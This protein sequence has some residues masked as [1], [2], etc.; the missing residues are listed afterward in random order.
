MHPA[1]N[2]KC[3]SSYNIIDKT[4]VLVHGAWHGSWCWIKIAENMT[5]KGYNVLTPDLPGH[6]ERGKSSFCDVS[7]SDYVTHMSHLINQ[8][9]GQVVLVGHSM[10]GV[11]I[12]QVAENMPHK[13]YKLVY[14]SGFVPNDRG[15]L[16]DEEQNAL[17]PTV[18]PETKIEK[19]K[20]AIHLN[21]QAASRLF[22]NSS[23]Q[24]DIRFALKCLQPQPLLPFV[25]K[26]TLSSSKFGSVSKLYIE[27]LR[28]NAILIED[29]QRMH[30]KI[31]G[32]EVLSIDTDHSPFFSAE[33]QLVEILVD[34]VN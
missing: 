27:C 22:Y 28:D 5:R 17:R 21:K 3:L 1:R 2:H 8:E 9:E 20:C 26:V 19:A 13:I 24:A 16:L 6:F 15:S 32:C 23:R 33:E 10:A 12:S 34:I 25:E 4:Y 7:L 18:S 11:V 29:Q 30:K 31:K 14:L